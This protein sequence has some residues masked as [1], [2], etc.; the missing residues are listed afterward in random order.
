MVHTCISHFQT[1]LK[2]DGTDVVIVTKHFR[3]QN[4]STSLNTMSLERPHSRVL[5]SLPRPSVGVEIN[6]VATYM[7]VCHNLQFEP[8]LVAVLNT[9]LRD[10]SQ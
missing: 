8:N 10:V 6:T 4:G 9:L 7:Y 2:E 1:I 3:N 5:F